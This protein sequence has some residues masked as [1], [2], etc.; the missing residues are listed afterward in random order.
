M[1]LATVVLFIVMIGYL[2]Y[3]GRQPYKHKVIDEGF[4]GEHLLDVTPRPLLNPPTYQFKEQPR[5]EAA[6]YVPLNQ[7]K[8]PIEV[9]EG[10]ILVEDDLARK[11][12]VSC[13]PQ[14]AVRASVRVLDKYGHQ[15]LS[16]PMEM[17]KLRVFVN[18][19][20]EKGYDLKKIYP[21]RDSEHIAYMTFNSERN[22]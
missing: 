21:S 1:P 15:A 3:F 22:T 8:K 16:D 6:A 18:E 17:E 12:P 2:V 20:H 11:G 4:T 9:I 14:G 5:R 10:E 13:E 7:F 19:M